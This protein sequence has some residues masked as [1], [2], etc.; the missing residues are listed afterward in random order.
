MKSIC[1]HCKIDINSSQLRLINRV[2]TSAYVC[3]DCYTLFNTLDKVSGFATGK[4]S[5]DDH[6]PITPFISPLR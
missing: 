1:A 4:W 6:G 3:S 5:D 2:D